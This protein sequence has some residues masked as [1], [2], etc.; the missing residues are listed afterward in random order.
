MRKKL[1][2]VLGLTLALSTGITGCAGNGSVAAT[3][4]ETDITLGEVKTYVKYQQA[5]YEQL[6]SVYLGQEID[7]SEVT[8]EETKETMGETMVADFLEEYKEMVIVAS[9][10]SDYQISLSEEQK[11]E[12]EEAAKKF[13]EA[14]SKAALK[15]MGATED[16]VISMLTYMTLQHLVEHEMR[17]TADKNVTDE[18]AAQKT[19]SYV[20]ISKEGTEQDEEGNTVALTEEEQATLKETA[21]TISKSGDDLDTAVQDAA[22]SVQTESYGEGDRGILEETVYEAADALKEGE[23]SGVIE[24][25]TMYY[26]V[27]MDSLYDEA[28]TEERKAEI[29]E[30]RE[31]AAYDELYKQW[32]E[33]GEFK[34]VDRVWA[35]IVL[36]NKYTIVSDEIES[37]TDGDATSTGDTTSNGEA[38]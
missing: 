8:N 2:A 17:D 34:T 30:E 25:D 31:Q 38:E 4:N 18:E 11:K 37:I 32:S 26:V 19:I 15:D 6:Y 13:I 1:L 27:R 24:T 36:K 20:T 16:T 29:I 23:I 5:L 12:I 21:E 7:W 10:A 22:Y 9:H 33:S 3:I 14:N 35:S 28:A